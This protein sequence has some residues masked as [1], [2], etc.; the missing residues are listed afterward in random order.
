MR[1]P[2]AGADGGSHSALLP[3]LPAGE[4]GGVGGVEGGREDETEEGGRG[5]RRGVG[6]P[7]R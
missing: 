6:G 1:V 5:R 3:S 2:V 7:C 4:E